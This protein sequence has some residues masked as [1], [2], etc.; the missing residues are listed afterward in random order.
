MRADILIEPEPNTIETE[1]PPL[2]TIIEDTK[3]VR[4]NNR[5]S[6]DRRLREV[7]YQ[8]IISAAKHL[9]DHLGFVIYEAYRPRLRQISLWN[10]VMSD[11]KK[12]YPNDNDETLALRCNR[13]VAN[14]YK[15][16]S[17]HQYGCAVDITLIDIN[18]NEEL[19]MGC[20]LQEFNEKT[21]T[22]T[23][24]IGDDQMK[25]RQILL[26]ALE[27]EGLVNYPPEWWHFSYGDR[28]WAIQNNL[29]ETLFDK[30]PF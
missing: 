2:I 14:P 20:G 13:F 10:E 17:G 27:K 29:D 9:P 11:I 15:H 28:Q 12:S 23:N 1:S 18:T 19:D 8:K 22:K 3:K 25:N 5:L 6:K 16:G 30:L 4:F 7:V 26:Q 21:E 24:L